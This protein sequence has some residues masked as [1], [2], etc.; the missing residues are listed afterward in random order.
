M[1]Y[2][3]MPAGPEI[4]RL[5]AE[6]MG[7]TEKPDKNGERYIADGIAVLFCERDGYVRFQPSTNIAHA[8]EVVEHMPTGFMMWD[9]GGCW[10]VEY[11]A[12]RADGF[13]DVGR[14]VAETLPL[15]IC[16]AALKAVGQ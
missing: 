10:S 7:W 12:G 16:R 5:V 14:T 9:Q 3:E 11:D 15:A 8:M 2:D 6:L 4:D 1:N 13:R